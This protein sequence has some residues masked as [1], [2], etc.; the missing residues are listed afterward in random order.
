MHIEL[1]AKYSDHTLDIPTSQYV[2]VDGL[3]IFYRE[4]GEKAAPVIL[5]LHG[6]PSSS[7][8]FRNLMPLLAKQYRVIAPDFPGFGF[9]D[10]PAERD[11][12]YT[13]DNLARTLGEFVNALNLES[14]AMYIF[15]YGAPIGLRLALAAPERVTAVISQNGN[16]YLDGLGTSWAPIRKYWYDQSKENREALKEFLSFDSTKAQYLHGAPLPDSVSPESYYLDAALMQRPGND[17][18]QLDLLLDYANNLK[19]YPAFQHFFKLTQVPTLAIWGRFDP[20]F[21]PA[22]AEAFKKDNK[23]ATIEFLDAGHFA[24]ETHTGHIADRIHVVLGDA[25]R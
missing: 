13:F 9:T 20:F 8:M 10:V 25:I 17:E 23:H 5:L 7:H 19:L 22:G 4:A 12:V 16:A 21:I 14:Y 2:N 15:D 24:L 6:Y 11:Y 1:P 3:R 18:I